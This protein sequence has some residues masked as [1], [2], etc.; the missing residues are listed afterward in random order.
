MT[1]RLP[2]TNALHKNCPPTGSKPRMRTPAR[3]CPAQHA[4]HT[5]VSSTTRTCVIL[6]RGGRAVGCGVCGQTSPHLRCCHPGMTL[7]CCLASRLPPSPRQ[8]H[9]ARL[10]A[11]AT[12]PSRCHTGPS[13]C[14]LAAAG[15]PA[16]ATATRLLLPCPSCCHPAAATRLLPPGCCHRTPAACCFYLAQEVALAAATLTRLLPPG[17]CYPALN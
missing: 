12:L 8:R 9:P 15:H 1:D 2:K 7:P 5:L 17:C 13:C 11:A 14:H 16:P 4:G 10:P 6:S 3:H